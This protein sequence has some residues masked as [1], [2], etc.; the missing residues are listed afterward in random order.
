MSASAQV[1]LNYQWAGSI[2]CPATWGRLPGVAKLRISRIIEH[3]LVLKHVLLGISMKN[4]MILKGPQ[5]P[6]GVRRDPQRPAGVRKQPNAQKY[7]RMASIFCFCSLTLLDCFGFLGAVFFLGHH[8]PALGS[9]FKVR[10]N[11]FTGRHRRGPKSNVVFPNTPYP[12]L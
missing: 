5:R 4:M 3:I 8:L 12:P 9:I 2:F 7:K 6:A 11:R 1:W 10:K